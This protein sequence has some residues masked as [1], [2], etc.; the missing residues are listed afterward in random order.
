M[1]EAVANEMIVRF[2]AVLIALAFLLV[3]VGSAAQTAGPSPVAATAPAIA[4]KTLANGLRVV[5]V[6]DHAAAVIQSAIWYRFGSLYE[7]P[8]KTGLA[9]GLE[10]M[11]FRGTKDVSSGGLDDI[12]ARL[13]AIVNANTAEDY[14]HFYFVMPADRLELAL[15]L[16][17]D[18]MRGLLLR[19]ADWQ[20]EKGAVL[21]EYDGDFS[22][23]IYKLT[24]AVRQSTY[25]G[26]RYARTA[27][28]VRADVVRSTSADLHKYYDAYYAP[29]NATLVIT[30]DVHS[31][32]VFRYAEEYFGPIAAQTV[33]APTPDATPAPI[34]H[35]TI[36]QS[37]DYSYA[38]LDCAYRIPGDLDADAAATQVFANLI[39]S[40]RSIF[41][42]K[43]VLSKLA[44]GYSASPD[45]ALH[46]GIF[47]VLIYV[48][49]G[50][51]SD[52]VRQTFEDTMRVTIANGI[53]SQLLT[54]A[55]TANSRQAV[56]S[57][58]SISGLGDRYGY[59]YGVEGRDPSV[60]DGNVDALDD[61]A[62]NAAVKHY[63]SMPAVVGTLT[64]SGSR[65]AGGDAKTGGSVSDDFSKRA[66]NGP[67][68]LAPWARAGVSKPLE[69]A[70]KVDPTTFTLPNGLR[71][72]VQEVHSNPT[73]FVS[74]SI[75]VSP[76]FDP[77]AKVGVGAITSGLIGYGSSKHDY[78]GLLKLGDDLGADLNLGLQFG[79]H[80]LS[81]DFDTLLGV[82]ADGERHPTFPQQYF[83]LVHSQEL[84]AT[85]QRSKNPDF[86]AE[87]AFLSAI[88]APSDPILRDETVQSIGGIHS[89]DVRAY[90]ARYFRP[91]HTT[92]IVVGDIDT[93]DVRSKMTAAF[94]DWQNVGSAPT[95]TLPPIPLTRPSVH[96][97]PTQR[98][99]VSVHLGQRAIG[100]RSPD[101][102]AMNLINGVLGADG[103]FDTRL[104]HEIR[105]QRG[106][107]YGVASSLSVTRERG[108]L[109][110]FFSAAPRNVAPTIRL[111]KSN[112]ARL[113]AQPVGTDELTRTRTKLIAS[114][115]VQEESTQVLVSRTESIAR[116]RLPT[117][118]YRT[119]ARRYAGYSPLDLLRVA[120]KY[121]RPNALVEVYE[122]G[123]GSR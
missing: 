89:S 24:Q 35:P 46:E 111:V 51:K 110:V 37:A 93:A 57:R 96:V 34:V 94:G 104:M 7:T 114:T 44:L 26:T 31:A 98:D 49:P 66:P 14:T 18:R 87:H 106:L 123:L 71:V 120:R 15:H 20:L 19:N 85:S 68:L 61:A 40:E 17:A 53:E 12:G 108:T 121:I 109:E 116:N 107:A 70:S 103:A 42:K 11:M 84:S 73:V 23:P 22:Q 36:A 33:P 28:G 102:Y 8:G 99:A 64:P 112:L 100:R 72:Y 101:F 67:I 16:E 60:D 48:T 119:F 43:L 52:T 30:G 39:N 90:A 3:P 63:F 55:K 54:A 47:H 88:Y 78:V 56:Y 13:G 58:D 82:L 91:D 81:R 25:P 1:R 69:L 113:V 10:H 45:T 80:G 122:G 41:Y 32:D 97:I 86:R 105:E 95:T 38:V 76:T 92:I 29:N 62:M 6:E 115:L 65:A 83:D 21:S 117:D 5:V 4:Q 77:P 79:A 59:A 75:E 9:H 74:G 27:L 2:R 50:V 118:Y